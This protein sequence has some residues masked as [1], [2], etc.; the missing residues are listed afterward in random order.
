VT[1]AGWYEAIEA[2]MANQGAHICQARAITLTHLQEEI[3]KRDSV[4]PKAGLAIDGEYENRVLDGD[5]ID[6][7]EYVRQSVQPVNKK[8]F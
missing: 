2:D 3:I 1:D 7:I 4:F 6:D 5:T 8:H